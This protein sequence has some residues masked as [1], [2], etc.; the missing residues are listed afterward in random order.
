[1]Q[2]AFVRWAVVGILLLTCLGAQAQLG[3]PATAGETLTGKRLVLADAVRG[4]AVILLAGFSREGGQACGNW[5][6]AIHSDTALAGV[7][8]Y[9]ISMLAGAPAP[10]RGMI[11]NAMRKGMPVA[12][13]ENFVVLTQDEKLWRSCFG[14]STDKDP[15]VVLMDA[16]G[17]VRWHGHGAAQN[18]EPLLKTALK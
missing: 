9:Q 7:K 18:L 5:S 8:L 11:K 1:M 12:E 3:L 15:Y 13:Q 6:K 16:S 14:V 2:K 17:Q 10:F 4:H